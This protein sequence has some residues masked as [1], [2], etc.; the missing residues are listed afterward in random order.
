[1]FKTL[2]RFARIAGISTRWRAERKGRRRSFAT[3]PAVGFATPGDC[4]NRLVLRLRTR[5]NS[6]R[7]VGT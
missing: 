7:T 5:P 3:S 4:K 6:M 1:M 2:Y